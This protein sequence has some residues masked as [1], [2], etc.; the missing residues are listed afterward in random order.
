MQKYIFIT[1]GVASSL[2]KGI[3]TSAIGR[4]LKS[5]GLNVTAVKFDPYINVD[6][7]TMNPYQHGEVF[8]TV[9]GAE[10]DLDLGHYERFIDV[11]LH[12]HNN[13]TTGTI[14]E[15][16]ISRERR[17]EYLG[18]T[19]QVVPHITDEIKKRI[20]M[21]AEK[22]N[23]QLIL[24]EVGGTVGDIEGLPF[25][26]AIRQ[27]KREIGHG[28]S[29]NVHVTYI[30]YLK[31]AQEFK[32]KPTQHSVKE[33]R[34]IGIQPEV[35]I[36][37]S[38]RPIPAEHKE[39]MSLFCD[40]PIEAVIDVPDLDTIYRAPICL[41]DAGLGALIQ[42]RLNCSNGVADLEVW[43]DIVSKSQNPSSEVEVV[44]VGKYV[45]IKDAYLSV[46]E[47]LK[48]AS[49][50]LSNNLKIKYV[51]AEYL[52]SPD[53]ENIL[54]NSDGIIVP[55]GFGARG[56]EGKIN[57][58]S[59][60]RKNNLPFLGLCL[61]M[62]LAVIEFARSCC[63]LAGAHSSEFN[64]NSSFKVV[65][66]VPGQ[67]V[68]IGTG[69]TMRLGAYR[70]ELRNNTRA[71]KLYQKQFVLERHRHRYEVNPDFVSIL[72]T[73]GLIFSGWHNNLA[74]IIEISNHPFFMA[75]QFHPE[76]AS[77]PTQ[78]HPLFLGFIE[79]AIKNRYK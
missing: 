67:E 66:L 48:H 33:L 20:T 2:G 75:T 69:G 28:N 41:E 47:A 73:N 29:L 11:N 55:G 40:V 52:E 36:A 10:T 51:P 54:K 61:G 31:A 1:G 38:E 22:D 74:E 65:D 72:E 60:A 6:A 53:F 68:L 13:V 23:A 62:Q 30:P 32:T 77:R 57:A 78:P 21:V 7:G 70:A 9:D 34:S 15:T 19:V 50:H 27:L 25:L 43:K 58:I 59:Y 71:S 45:T 4:I 14:Y 37:R 76:F 18:G 56:I 26:E 3:T 16:V 24:V 8:V 46:V 12:K 63:G 42:E 5:R 35:L 17:G 44:L 39:K 64:E 79:S 49:I